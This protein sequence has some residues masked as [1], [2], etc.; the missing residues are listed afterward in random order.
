MLKKNVD[1]QPNQLDLNQR[2]FGLLG[3]VNASSAGATAT[4]AYSGH[5]SLSAIFGAFTVAG[6]LTLERYADKDHKRLK[7]HFNGFAV[8][9]L[10]KLA[11]GVGWPAEN[12][13]NNLNQNVKD[14]IKQEALLEQQRY[15]DIE[16]Q[17]ID[18][19]GR[20][21]QDQNLRFN[22]DIDPR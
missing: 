3:F 10:I 8:G 5:W 16:S 7:A 14:A 22:T 13:I 4:A 18:A 21:M 1:H 20:H 15:D 19:L 2:Y 17:L 9:A 12:A 6:L 11:V